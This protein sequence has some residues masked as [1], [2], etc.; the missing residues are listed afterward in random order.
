MR[1]TEQ[2]FQSWKD[3]TSSQQAID[4]YKQSAQGLTVNPLELAATPEASRR[5]VE[6]VAASEASGKRIRGLQKVSFEQLKQAMV[7]KGAANMAN[8]AKSK[9]AEARMK[10]AIN[11]GRSAW[12]DIKATARTMSKGSDQDKLAIVQMAWNKMRAAYGH[13]AG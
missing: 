2:I 1:T 8:G 11:T 6:G 3:R 9:L 12:E 5:Y 10:A 13:P 7:E 4:K